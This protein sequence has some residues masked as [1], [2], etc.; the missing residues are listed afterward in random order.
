MQL[1]LI[2]LYSTGKKIHAVKRSLMLE[3]WSFY[4]ETWVFHFLHF[5]EWC[6]SYW[7]DAIRQIRDKQHTVHYNLIHH[8]IQK[9]TIQRK[10]NHLQR[11]IIGAHQQE[12]INKDEE[13][14]RVTAR[15]L[16]P[17]GHLSPWSWNLTDVPEKRHTGICSGVMTWTGVKRAEKEQQLKK[18]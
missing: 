3:G 7:F 9:M 1:W 11:T 18:L 13:Q 12:I 16:N 6:S 14:R 2:T 17:V 15:Q 4:P 10:Y 5:L 8:L